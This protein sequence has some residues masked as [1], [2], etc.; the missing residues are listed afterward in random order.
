MNKILY[1]KYDNL[2]S[3]GINSISSQIKHENS[4]RSV[5]VRVPFAS[6][7]V[8]TKFTIWM[9]KIGT[10]DD[11]NI[12]VY[13]FMVFLVNFF[14]RCTILGCL[15][16]ESNLLICTWKPDVNMIYFCCQM[17][18]HFDR[19]SWLWANLYSTEQKIFKIFFNLPGS[20][21]LRWYSLKAII[22]HWRKLGW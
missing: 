15:R 8:Q 12:W 3:I 20:H 10:F 7:F 11:K 21:N 18:A 14:L 6:F 1:E 17:L 22:P 5:D 2:N 4:D 19:W 16:L 13:K 9:R